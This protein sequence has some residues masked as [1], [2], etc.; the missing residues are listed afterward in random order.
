[1]LPKD[2][3]VPP[4][5]SVVR[6]RLGSRTGLLL[7]SL[8]LLLLLGSRTRVKSG[9]AWLLLSTAPAAAAAAAAAGPSASLGDQTPG[10]GTPI[11]KLGAEELRSCCC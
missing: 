9:A 8:M 4:L 6:A 3:D 10:S 7:L 5:A 11:V 1:V 2:A